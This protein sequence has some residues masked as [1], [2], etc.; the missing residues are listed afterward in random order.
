[1]VVPFGQIGL[2]LGANIYVTHIHYCDANFERDVCT[3]FL[4]TEVQDVSRVMQILRLY[5][6]KLWDLSTCLQCWNLVEF[7]GT[8]AKAKIKWS[9]FQGEEVTS[10]RGC[11]TYFWSCDQ[12]RKK[13]LLVQHGITVTNTNWRNKPTAS[14]DPPV[15]PDVFRQWRERLFLRR[16]CKMTCRLHNIQRVVD[17]FEATYFD[18]SPVRQRC[19]WFKNIEQP[20]PFLSE[21]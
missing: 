16:L 1:M 2:E 11:H 17:F 3:A 20:R 6:D 4:R 15:A 14:W 12:S 19:I 9:W 8:M 18:G 7:S 21:T 5:Y 13:K 10:K